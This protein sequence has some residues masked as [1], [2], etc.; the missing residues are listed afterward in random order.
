MKT[1][2]WGFYQKLTLG[3]V[4]ASSVQAAQAGSLVA[5]DVFLNAFDINTG[6][7]YNADLGVVV[8]DFVGAANSL[9]GGQT[10]NYTLDPTYNTWVSGALAAGDT[11]EYNI[12]GVNAATGYKDPNQG[13][14]VTNVPPY[15]EFT[16]APADITFTQDVAYFGK[17]VSAINLT[18]TGLLTDSTSLQE[19]GFNAN[20]V[21]WGIGE[22]LGTNDLS[23][24]YGNGGLNQLVAQYLSSPGATVTKNGP[25]N[26]SLL[27]GYFSLS[28]T[29]VIWTS[30]AAATAV[31]LPAASWLFIGGLLSLLVGKKRNQVTAITC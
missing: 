24:T 17:R 23:S 15:G 12:A 31:P 5:N 28:N 16:Y 19:A 3:I 18:G 8:G 27:P 21:S 10:L 11:I 4:L 26:M 20:F 2:N 1:E 29:G 13:L 30:T 7:S 14:L 22:G 6:Y 9:S 25:V